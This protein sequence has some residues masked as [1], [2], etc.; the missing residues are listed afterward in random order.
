ML[1][2]MFRKISLFPTLSLDLMSFGTLA[3]ENLPLG[4]RRRLQMARH[5]PPPWTLEAARLARRVTWR[6]QGE[7]SAFG[8]AQVLLDNPGNLDRLWAGHAQSRIIPI[9]G[10]SKRSGVDAY[11]T[12]G[13]NGSIS[14]P[15][16]PIA[17]AEGTESI[18]IELASEAVLRK[19]S[20]QYPRAF[21]TRVNM[22]R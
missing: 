14:K 10:K 15:G 6:N 20:P 19:P 7:A 8:D 16:A 13:E 18:M 12:D 5:R 4:R 9:R 11:K 22:V 3:R 17:L 21:A 1:H 2:H